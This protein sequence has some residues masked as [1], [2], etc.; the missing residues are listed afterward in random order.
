MTVQALSCWAF[1]YESGRNILREKNWEIDVRLTS[2]FDHSLLKLIFSN[3]SRFDYYF[4]IGH[5]QFQECY[6]DINLPHPF[7]LGLNAGCELTKWLFITAPRSTLKKSEKQFIF[8]DKATQHCF[9]KQV[10]IE[11]AIQQRHIIGL[12]GKLQSINNRASHTTFM[13]GGGRKLE[14]QSFQSDGVELLS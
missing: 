8:E 13:N 11:E 12:H 6:S 2:A 1:L 14:F 7:V 10:K 3:S 9:A 5:V 4:Q